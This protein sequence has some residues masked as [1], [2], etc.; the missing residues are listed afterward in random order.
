MPEPT[1]K[2]WTD[3]YSYC[4]LDPHFVNNANHRTA[5]L[6]YVKTVSMLDDNEK[7][8]IQTEVKNYAASWAK[9]EKLIQKVDN[10]K[11]FASQ[12]LSLIGRS[13]CLSSLS[14]SKEYADAMVALGHLL[15]HLTFKVT[16]ST[17][18]NAGGTVTL[19]LDLIESPQTD[20][21]EAVLFAL[22]HELGHSVNLTLKPYN[23]ADPSFL[24]VYAAILPALPDSTSANQKLEYFA[25]AFAAVFLVSAAGIDSKKVPGAAKFLFAA[26]G[27]GGDHPPGDARVAKVEECIKNK[28]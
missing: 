5:V 11:D 12:R 15:S 27:G 4:S 7:D 28:C 23:P 25:D 26:E 20:A 3:A 2:E 6:D 16:R 10:F 18:Q 9:V 1:P 14:D 8:E 13:R 17:T 24:T 22:A 21:E 19:G